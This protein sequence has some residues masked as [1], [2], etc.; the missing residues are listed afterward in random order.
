MAIHCN[1]TVRSKDINIRSELTEEVTRV[2]CVH[3]ALVIGLAHDALH[4]H[5][6]GVLLS[7]DVSLHDGDGSNGSVRKRIFGAQ[8]T[9]VARAL[10]E[11][12]FQ[13]VHQAG[14]QLD[15]L[16]RLDLKQK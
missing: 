1:D 15:Q 6:V 16:C 5:L 13:G 2:G 10:R 7:V 12:H 4:A 3:R 11:A 8:G 9:G 14:N